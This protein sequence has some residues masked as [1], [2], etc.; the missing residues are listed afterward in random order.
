MSAEVLVFAPA[1]RE[2]DDPREDD[3]PRGDP[4]LRTR[5]VAA[6]TLERLAADGVP[7]VA[8]LDDR[9]T[10]AGLEGAIRDETRGVALF[11]HGRVA[12]KGAPTATDDAIM[13][14]DGP[15][16]DRDNLTLLRDRW[17]HAVACHSGTE[18]ATQ[19]CAH[20]AECFVGYDVSLTVEWDPDALPEEIEPLMID[21]VTKTTRNLA[22][23][24]RDERRLLADVNAIAEDI[25]DWCR[26]NADRAEGLYLEATAHQLVDRLVC[27][28]RDTRLGE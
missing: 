5:W 7:T 10:R 2:P 21:L 28:K 13:G 12:R 8:V 20:G 22:G 19:A 4:L 9:A 24:V 11:S 23:G 17:G 27:R 1:P 18:M 14:L 6:H 25:A 16:L 3:D 26:N 15:A